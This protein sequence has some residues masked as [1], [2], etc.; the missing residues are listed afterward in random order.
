MYYSH[1]V[2]KNNTPIYTQIAYDNKTDPNLIYTK[3][4]GLIIYETV[5]WKNHTAGLI[6]PSTLE[7]NPSMQRCL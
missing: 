2:T 6:N 7:L 1:C 4:L 3:F 5:T